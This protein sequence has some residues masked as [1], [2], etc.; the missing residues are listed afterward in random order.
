MCNRCDIGRLSLAGGTEREEE[1]S[2][3]WLDCNG[4]VGRPLE[5][6]KG[7][8]RSSS[9][10]LWKFSRPGEKGGVGVDSLWNVSFRLE[11][12]RGVDLADPDGIAEIPDVGPNS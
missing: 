9:E 4:G 2:V 3:R 7:E 11:S 8:G 6:R 1:G 5:R 10:C 12:I